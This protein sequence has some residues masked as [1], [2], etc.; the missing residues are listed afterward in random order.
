MKGI[1]TMIIIPGHL[2]IITCEEWGAKQPLHAVEVRDYPFKGGIFHH[3]ASANHDPSL[4]PSSQKRNAIA[5][6]QAIQRAHQIT[7]GWVDSGMNFLVS[8]DA[9]ITEGRHNSIR[10]LQNK[11]TVVSAHCAGDG[12]WFNDWVGV[13]IEGSH[14]TVPVND[15][16]MEA[17]IKLFAW[18]SICAGFDT[19]IIQGHRSA[20]PGQTLCPGDWLFNQTDNIR[21]RVHV[22]K[23][24]FSEIMKNK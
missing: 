3:T 2:E 17:V 22:K 4:L 15:K 16:Q 5:L 8:V 9:I 1:I 20:L 13:E 23:L 14:M 24:E 19:S 18:S 12:L 10:T 6:A 7:N 21:K 11:Q